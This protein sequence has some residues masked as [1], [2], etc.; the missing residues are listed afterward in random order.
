MQNERMIPVFEKAIEKLEQGLKE[1]KGDQ[2]VSVMKKPVHDAL[3]GFCEQSEEF[4]R[5]VEEG[6]SFAECMAAVAKGCGSALSD[7]EAYKR[8]VKFYFPGADVRMTLTID[9]GNA[10][11]LEERNIPSVPAG[12]GGIVLDLTDFL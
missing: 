1:C 3:A 2:K 6:K 5:A 8:A 4:A 11:A 10:A 7:L 12:T 9:T